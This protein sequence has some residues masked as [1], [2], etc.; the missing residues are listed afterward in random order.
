MT[1]DFD[2]AL[3]DAIGRTA[4]AVE[5]RGTDIAAGARRRHRRRARARAA[6]AVALATLVVA[7]GVMGVAT[8]RTATGHTTATAPPSPSGRPTRP[9]TLPPY[10]ELMALLA[11]APSPETIWPQAVRH[12]PG[13]L[14][15]GST[16]NVITE[17]EPGVYVV[18]VS[19]GVESY[20]SVYR[21]V[22]ASGDL[23]LLLDARAL[24]P[25][26]R[27]CCPVGRARTLA[28][29]TYTAVQTVRSGHA[30]ELWVVA[31]ATGATVDHVTI[32]AS[33]GEIYSVDRVEGHEV[34]SDNA[35]TPH[36]YSST[37]P[38][39][40]LPGSAGFA[41]TG[42]DGWAVA[43]S[44]SGV[45]F[46]NLGTGQRRSYDAPSTIGGQP[47]AYGDPCAAV[48]CTAT[49]TDRGTKLITVV[50]LDGVAEGRTAHVSAGELSME[51]VGSGFALFSGA[52]QHTVGIWDMRTG[53]VAAVHIANLEDLD[54][55][56]GPDILT[57][58][59]SGGDKVLLDLAT[60]TG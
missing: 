44:G 29:G 1:I 16:Y 19:H 37:D 36:L 13:H 55:G 59:P 49:A 18:Q 17:V 34:W 30:T 27:T 48:W 43:T 56:T 3:A 32:P 38:G 42:Q 58:P 9:P 4:D 20:G 11:T 45:T 21:Y 24:N 22:P 41:M 8:L 51:V 47:L 15:D 54:A 6:G 57:L 14:P 50:G 46:W 12:L 10:K 35:D 7:G 5:L 26:P 40:A 23:A 52:D 31:T 39:R 25:D 53:Q 2:A 28:G 33:E 60:V